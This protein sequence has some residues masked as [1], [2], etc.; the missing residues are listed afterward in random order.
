M[1]FYWWISTLRFWQKYF[2][3]LVDEH[4][5]VNYVYKKDYDEPT[6]RSRDYF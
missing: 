3:F 6:T 5:F 4:P 2:D 1:Q